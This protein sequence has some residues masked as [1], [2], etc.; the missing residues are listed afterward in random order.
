MSQPIP[1]DV[2]SFA[3]RMGF[4]AL[5]PESQAMLT[6]LF[7]PALAEAWTKDAVV[8]L[9]HALKEK[10]EGYLAEDDIEGLF[11]FLTANVPDLAAR[12][13]KAMDA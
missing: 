3:K 4:D 8:G 10:A 5:R 13:K 6:E 7:G 11:D 1:N 12:I 9:P 2:A